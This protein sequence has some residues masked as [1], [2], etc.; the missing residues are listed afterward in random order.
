MGAVHGFA[1]SDPVRPRAHPSRVTERWKL[2]GNYPQRLLKNVLRSIGIPHDRL[3]VLVQ[4]SLQRGE[5]TV[6]RFS[7]AGLCTPDEEQ[8]VSAFGQGALI[9]SKAISTRP[10]EREM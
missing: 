1:G 5:Q 9:D 3:D 7:V 4:L 2:P 8:L 6:E 10:T